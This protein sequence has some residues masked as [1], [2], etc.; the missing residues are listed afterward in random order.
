M[1]LLETPNNTWFAYC[2]G[3]RAGLLISEAKE[4]SVLQQ[5]YA[6]MRSQALTSE[7]SMSLLER[8]R[9]AL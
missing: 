6:R 3:Q 1:Q 8:I 2:E 5:R 4:V 7:E 9:G